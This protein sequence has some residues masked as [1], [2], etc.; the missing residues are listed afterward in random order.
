[1]GHRQ[2][3][4]ALQ[5]LK[6]RRDLP[7]DRF[8]AILADFERNLDWDALPVVD[9]VYASCS[10]PFCPPDEFQQVWQHLKGKVV[11]GGRLACHFFGCCYQ[12]FSDKEKAQMTFLTRREVENLFE[13]F[14]I[15]YFQ[16]HE[17]D[18][19]SGTGQAIHAHVFEVIAEKT[20]S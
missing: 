8:I 16:E 10:L 4:K 14:H 11:P 17:E 6:E 13:G 5:I 9:F 12:G 3:K 15:E 20:A 7:S 19:E 18:G 1:M 2:S